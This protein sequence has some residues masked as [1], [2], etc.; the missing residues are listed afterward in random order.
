MAN[1]L[2]NE[3]EIWQKI[4]AEARPLSPLVWEVLRHHLSNDTQI[5]VYAGEDLRCCLLE[6]VQTLVTLQAQGKTTSA[7]DLIGSLQ[8]LVTVCDRVIIHGRSVRCFLAKLSE[9][10]HQQ[11]GIDLVLKPAAPQANSVKP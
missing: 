1:P 10:T 2:N 3:K 11:E 7:D 5:S 9:A 4:K 6:L 8:E